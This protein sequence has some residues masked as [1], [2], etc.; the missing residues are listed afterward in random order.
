MSS[1]ITAKNLSYGSKL[2]PFLAALHAQAAG[3]SPGPG[4]LG[5]NQRRPAK[6]RSASDEAED[7]PLV[8]DDDGNAVA[9][10]LDRHGAVVRE[11]S[12]EAERVDAAAAAAA[13]ASSA[14]PDEREAAEANKSAFGGRKRKAG[15][16]VGGDGD[17]DASHGVWR[18]DD[19][20]CP[21]GEDGQRPAPPPGKK[22]G[23]KAK[24]IKLSFDQ[25]DGDG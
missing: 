16:V 9:V 20:P 7:A 13:P 10:Q 2:P 19:G 1:K 5:A 4:P 12:V 22:A 3:A 14:G 21:S 17:G 18:G 11:A 24:K 8:V 25:D 6:Q 15:R 23:K